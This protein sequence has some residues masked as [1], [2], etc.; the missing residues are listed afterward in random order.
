M[1]LVL[2]KPFVKQPFMSHP[3]AIAIQLAPRCLDFGQRPEADSAAMRFL[4]V[5]LD[6]SLSPLHAG[7][8][9]CA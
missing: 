4:T 1:Q 5:L 7:P 6:T 8:E 9:G 3:A 2:K